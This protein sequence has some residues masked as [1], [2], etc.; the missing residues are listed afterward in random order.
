MKVEMTQ[1]KS[2]EKIE[3]FNEITEHLINDPIPSEYM[4]QVSKEARFNEYPFQMLLK[5]KETEQSKKHHPEG[6]VWNHTMMVLDEAAKVKHHSK[7]KKAFLWAAL[8]HDIGK[9]DTTKLRT[10]RITSY[11]HDKVGEK[12]CRKFLQALSD[13]SEFIDTV[14]DLVRYHMHMLYILKNLPYADPKG[15]IQKVDIHEIALLCR[16]DRL[17]RIGVNRE[18]EEDNYNKFLRSLQELYDQ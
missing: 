11:D 5:L 9:P 12:L 6:N 17:G 13:D 14:C 2:N 4:K 7:N 18:E 10:G 15:L 8:L 16:C 3:L 1:L